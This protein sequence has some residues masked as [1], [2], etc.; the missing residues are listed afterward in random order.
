MSLQLEWTLL[1]VAKFGNCCSNT[2]KVEL[3]GDRVAVVAGG[4]L[5]CCGSPLF[6]R[7]HLGSGYYLTLAKGAKP[8]SAST[9]GDTDLEDSMDA[10]QK[11]EPGSQ[12]RWAGVPQL[13]AMVQRQVPGARLVEDLP[14]EL[15]LVLPYGGALDGSFTQLFHEV[16]Q[17]LREL[18]LASCGISDTSLE[19]IFLKVV[20]D[21]A[22]DTDPEGAAAAG[23]RRQHPCTGITHPDV[24]TRLKI[25]PKESAL[26]NGEPVGSAPET[27]ALQGSGP[28][29][30]GRVQGWALTCQQLRALLLKRFLLARRSRRGLFAQVYP[31]PC[32]PLLRALRSHGWL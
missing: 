25:L 22:V 29:A 15:V 31:L 30:T 18:G 23:S 3:L 2:G 12:G 19:E 26:E 1:P 21:C 32:T 13:L 17:H 27:Q 11:R 4:R 10:E 7:R 24:T 14:H 5:C 16:D 20:E 6:L 8:L 9:K 28:N